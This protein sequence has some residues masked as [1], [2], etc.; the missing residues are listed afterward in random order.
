MAEAYITVGV[1][2]SSVVDAVTN[3]DLFADELWREL[4]R[5]LAGGMIRDDFMDMAA[6]YDTDLLREMSATLGRTAL[7]LKNIVKRR[8]E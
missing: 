4:I 3:S 2:A 6:N 1:S 5:G 8:E 7:D